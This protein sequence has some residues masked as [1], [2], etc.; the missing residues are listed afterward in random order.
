MATSSRLS[1]AE[2]QWL[3]VLGTLNEFQARLAA[4]QRAIEF[5]RGGISHVARLTG[6][7]RPTITRGIAELH[8]RRPLEAVET[9]RIRRAR[10]GRPKGEARDPGVRRADWRLPT[11][12]RLT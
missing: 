3:R 7:A 11:D 9:G 10:A 6:M 4:A 12:R 1:D 5:G 2:R 8:G